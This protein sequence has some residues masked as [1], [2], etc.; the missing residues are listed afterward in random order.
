MVEIK[1]LSN[2]KNMLLRVLENYEN[3]LYKDKKRTPEYKKIEQKK[4]EII[5]ERLNGKKPVYHL[6]KALGITDFGLGDEE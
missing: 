4:L 2:E 1:M 6:E 3:Y 5:R